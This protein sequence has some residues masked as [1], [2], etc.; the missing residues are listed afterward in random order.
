MMNEL[1]AISRSLTV[2]IATNYYYI[3]TKWDLST[4]ISGAND[5][6]ADTVMVCAGKSPASVLPAPSPHPLFPIVYRG[7][8]V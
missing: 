7:T 6:H 2:C 3:F 5:I 8:A 1:V 4:L